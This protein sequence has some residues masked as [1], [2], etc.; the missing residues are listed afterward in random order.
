MS[1]SETDEKHTERCWK[2]ELLTPMWLLFAGLL[3]VAVI[4]YLLMR[5][6]PQPN[7]C[8]RLPEYPVFGHR[9]NGRPSSGVLVYLPE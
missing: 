1:E 8:V 3:N 9:M 5:P 4:V 2:D 7:Q 6:S